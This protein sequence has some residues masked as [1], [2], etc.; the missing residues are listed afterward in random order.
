MQPYH[1]YSVE[2][3]IRLQNLH[4]AGKGVREIARETGRNPS[5]LSH[6]LKQN[7]NQDGTYHAWRGM[8]FSTP[9]CF[10]RIIAPGTNSA[11]IYPFP[12]FV[13]FSYLT[14]FPDRYTRETSPR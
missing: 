3:R 14:V 7:G 4:A 2:E 1:H 13:I 5:S 12:R 9:P 8:S 10:D 11:R 6:K